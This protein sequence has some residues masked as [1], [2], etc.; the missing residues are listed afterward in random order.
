[1]K[2]EDLIPIPTLEELMTAAKAKLQDM[3]FRITNLRP[4]G[5]FYTLLEMAHQ[6]LVD[7][8]GL[9][10]KVVPQI[11]VDTAEDIWL[12]AKGAEFEV[13]RKEA[14][15]TQGNVIL[16]RYA[17][18]D[19]VIIPA[20]SIVAT[21]V[22]I[23]GNRLQYIVREQ[24]ALESG[25]LETV[26]SVEA[27]YAG[28]QYN[29]GANQITELVTHIPGID[30]VRN[31]ENWIT[32]EGTDRE[33]DESFRQRIKARWNQL[34]WG[35]SRDAYISW[36]LEIDGVQ[37]VLVDDQ[38]PRGQGTVD[39][40]IVSAAGLPSQQLIDEV[41]AHLDERKPVCADVLV[42]GPEP[43][44]VDFDIVLYVHPDYGDLAVIEE[45]AATIIDTMF[46]YGDTENTEILKA[47]PEFG[48]TR[49]QI[50]ANLMRIEH[51]VNI[52]IIAPAADVTVSG[53]QLAVKGN[54]NIRAQRVS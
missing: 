39:V 37:M 32:R 18:G 33:T 48:V 45:Q 14:Q 52:D 20:G 24:T 27:E 4:G 13:Y 50:S 49:A 43:V 35:G 41:Q 1:V 46:Q 53:R 17:D 21:K 34:S 44:I 42:Q 7:L 11:Y 47:S 12:D 30:Y 16:G 19:N 36:A 54:V 40:I 6:G 9:L 26:V 15:K 8:Y 5:V 3:K 22:D 2:P 28:A 31:N 10:R 23:N 29:V 38:H 51:V 25:N